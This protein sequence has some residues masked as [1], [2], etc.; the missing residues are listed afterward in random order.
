MIQSPGN[1]G[2]TT[3][4]VRTPGLSLNLIT[5]G[6]YNEATGEIHDR[7]PGLDSIST[8]NSKPELVAPGTNIS[9]PGISGSGSAT[10]YSTPHVAAFAANLM[11]NFAGYKFN[12]YLVKASLISGARKDVAGDPDRVEEGGVDYLQHVNGDQVYYWRGNSGTF[13]WLDAYDGSV[14]G[15]LT[16]EVWLSSSYSE[17]TITIAWLLRGSF[18]GDNLSAVQKMGSNYNLM[19]LRP[20]GSYIGGG[21]SFRNAYDTTTFNPDASGFYKIRIQRASNHDSSAKFHL[22]YAVNWE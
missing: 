13:D 16:H 7:S 10:S 15:W 14:D 22:G 8:L 18:I 20:N 17:V 3:N 9:V 11:E 12:P 21:W 2:H 6:N 19:V 4:Y 5:V 1:T